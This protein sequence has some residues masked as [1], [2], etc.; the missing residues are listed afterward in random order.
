MNPEV[1][2]QKSI[3]TMA[4]NLRE[5]MVAISFKPSD[6]CT[7]NGRKDHRDNRRYDGRTP[8]ALYSKWMYMQ[9][10]C[11]SFF[12]IEKRIAALKLT[13]NFSNKDKHRMSIVEFSV[14]KQVIV[15]IYNI[16][17]NDK[18]MFNYIFELDTTYGFF[19]TRI[20]LIYGAPI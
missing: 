8:E 10:D 7:I 12:A 17:K 11:T 2:N 9:V 4:V 18:Y 19:S 16:R 5:L 3:K 13:G 15:H 6:S 1:V 14:G 20:S